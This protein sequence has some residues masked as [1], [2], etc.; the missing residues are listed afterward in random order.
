MNEKD[1]ISDG[2]L[3]KKFPLLF[4]HKS[5]QKFDVPEG[6]FEG[7]SKEIISKI[8]TSEETKVIPINKTISLKKWVF[9]G[10]IAAAFI[11][12]ILFFIPSDNG[13]VELAFT[14]EEITLFTEDIII[15]IDDDLIY[16]AV[17]SEDM[18]LI[19]DDLEYE[20][21]IDDNDIDLEELIYEL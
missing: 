4:D 10:G 20:D 3:K 18:E 6:Y 12:G 17:Y 7:L 8:K 14:D 5:Q 2:Q 9:Y 19:E 16:E 11:I 15:E 1:Y 21:F 13:S